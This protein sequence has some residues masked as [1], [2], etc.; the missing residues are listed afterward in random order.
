[1]STD[2]F[3]IHLRAYR[4]C[5]LAHKDSTA[6][7]WDDREALIEGLNEKQTQLLMNSDDWDSGL[8]F[9]RWFRAYSILFPDDKPE[10]VP[11]PCT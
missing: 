5:G 2:L 1:M 10:L 3:R 11:T 7:D 6:A 9:E 4:R 8:E